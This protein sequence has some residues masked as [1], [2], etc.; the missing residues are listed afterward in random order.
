MAHWRQVLPAG[1][2]FDVPYAELVT[3]QERWSRKILE[4]AGLGWDERCL[5]F[6]TLKRPVTTASNWQVRQKIYQH[7]VERW[8]NYAAFIGPLLELRHPA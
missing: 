4:F 8:R 3:D 7:S 5:D 2:I 1:T 6:H